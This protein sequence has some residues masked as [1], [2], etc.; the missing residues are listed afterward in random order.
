[1]S[2]QR[3]NQTTIT[4]KKAG[5]FYCSGLFSLW[6]VAART[7]PAAKANGLQAHFVSVFRGCSELKIVIRI[8]KG[9]HFIVVRNQPSEH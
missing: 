5:A 1:V 3:S 9:E 8:G 4:T 6:K 7:L 2:G